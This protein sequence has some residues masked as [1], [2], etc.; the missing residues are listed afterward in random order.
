MTT[1]VINAGA[2]RVRVAHPLPNGKLQE[3]FSAQNGTPAELADRVRSYLLRQYENQRFDALVLNAERGLMKVYRTSL[4]PDLARL[5]V[6][7][8]DKD[9]SDRDLDF[10]EV[11]FKP[12][13]GPKGR[14]KKWQ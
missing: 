1:W 13:K 7:E 9:N 8:D 11:R 6:A 3:G 2:D 10:L 5:V 4:E 12:H 14:G